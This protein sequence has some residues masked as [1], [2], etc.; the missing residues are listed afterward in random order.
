MAKST[1]AQTEPSM[2][3]PETNPAKSIE[4]PIK[5]SRLP[6]IST[7]LAIIAL[8]AAL[9]S[10][11][12]NHQQAHQALNQLEQQKSDENE[13]IETLE[14]RFK[15]SN[16]AM[17]KQI[18]E[19]SKT[20]Q[21]LAQSSQ[22]QEDWPLFKARYYLELAQINAYWSTDQQSTIALLQQAD[23]LLAKDSNQQIFSLRQA[24]ATE[25]SELK[26][27]P[28]L[29]I[30]GLLSQ[31]DAAQKALLNLTLKQPMNKTTLN[32]T[33]PVTKNSQSWQDQLKSSMS[34]LEKLVI[35]RHHDE[36]IK[37][38]LSPLHQKLVR[39][40]IQ[41]N[42]QEAQWAIMQNSPKVYQ[43]ALTRA[44]EEIKRSFDNHSD[45]TKALINQ[46][47]ALENVHLPTAKIKLEKSLSLL[48]QILEKR[49]FPSD[50]KPAAP[51][52]GTRQ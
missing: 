12:E 42:L 25:I 39:D 8:L 36:D 32:E 29:D 10:L 52:G 50:N 22:N 49:N 38:I 2:Q 35:I 34:V 46:L 37:P 47:E 11:Y 17:Q 51:Q 24:L 14:Q 9:Y 18:Q 48:N 23:S 16:T 41:F 40:S 13:S 1:K 6:F 19:M 28:N 33:S 43:L 27:L 20:I 4:R 21:N 3:K 7:I 5:K 44:I 26:A 30:P 31:L 15:Q 45:S